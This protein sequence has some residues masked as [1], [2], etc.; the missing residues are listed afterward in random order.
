MTTH[1][2][3]SSDEAKQIVLDLGIAINNESYQTARIY[4]T[5]DMKYEGPFGTRVGAE[6]YLEQIERLRLKFHIHRIFADGNDI[7]VLYNIDSA[8]VTVFACGL[9]QIKDG[10]VSSLKVVFDPRPPLVS[11]KETK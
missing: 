10:K 4:L 7:C 2:V 1:A 8:G 11:P 3:L 6:A 5:D 9:F